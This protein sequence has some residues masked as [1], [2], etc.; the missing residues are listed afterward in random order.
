[1]TPIQDDEVKAGFFRCIEKMFDSRD[2]GTIRTEWG[3]FATLRG[4]S[5][6]AK[7]DIYTMAQED[8]LWWWNCH[9]PKYL[10]T[11]LAIRLLS[12]VSSSSAVERNWSTYSFIHSLK[13]NIFTS[14]RAEKLVVVHSALRLMDHK[15]LVYKE[16]PVARWDVEPEKPSQIDED[17]PTTLDAGLVGVSLRDLDL[18]ESISSSEEEFVDD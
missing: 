11:T 17:D 1:M 18:Q 13:R 8:P 14:K 4:Y 16:S 5:G 3:R 15:T 7:M 2:V 12:Q 9:G 10:T 6:A